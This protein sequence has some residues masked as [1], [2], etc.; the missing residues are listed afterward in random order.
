MLGLEP[1]TIPTQ[2][3]TPVVCRAD[4]EELADLDH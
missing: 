1:G 2:E 3:T 4:R